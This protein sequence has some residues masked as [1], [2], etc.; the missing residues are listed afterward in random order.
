MESIFLPFW[1]KLIRQILVEI[2]K[3]FSL[4]ER[5]ITR[6]RTFHWENRLP[7]RRKGFYQGPYPN[8]HAQNAAHPF[9]Q[10]VSRVTEFTTRK[11]K[12]AIIQCVNPAEYR[13]IFLCF[14]T[15]KLCASEYYAY[16]IDVSL[17]CFSNRFA[18]DA[19]L[20]TARFFE[21]V[22]TTEE[23]TRQQLRPAEFHYRGLIPIASFPLRPQ[24]AR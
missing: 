18:Y 16:R 19:T 20:S 3:G 4:T 11:I 2:G 13:I 15:D 5:S 21:F 12:K 10:N 24:S 6:N 7:V 17:T 9:I 23:K 1:L 22:V 8:K 14:P